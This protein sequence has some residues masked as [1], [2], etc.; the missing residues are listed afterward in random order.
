MATKTKTKTKISSQAVMDELKTLALLTG[1]V[2]IG[3]MGGK[4]IDTMLKVD[5]SLPGFNAKAFARPVLLVGAG[6][7]AN[8]LIKNPN[9]KM[10]G[11]GV[12]AAGVLS[13]V[14][15]VMKKDLLAGLA[16]FSFNGIQGF[17]G[18]PSVYR[19]PIS[20]SVDRYNPDLP[21]LSS[22]T[23][24]P[25]NDLEGTPAVFEII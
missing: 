21:V 16:D 19:E 23:D 18:E 8:L 14:K 10:L 24:Y 1:G 15:L 2:V 13:G 7:A 9:I 17:L 25:S 22:T 12:G 3:S 5:L 6:T 20:L 4:M 11:V